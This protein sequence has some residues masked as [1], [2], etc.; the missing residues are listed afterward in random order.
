MRFRG[1]I[2]AERLGLDPTEFRLVCIPYDLY[3]RVGR[4]QGWGHWPHWTHFYGYKVPD[5]NRLGAVGGGDGRFG[6]VT[7]L[8][9]LS[10]RDAR[11]SVYARFAVVRRARMVA[12][13]W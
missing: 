4:A 10:R 12:R 11:Y 13:W 7:D 8:V 3:T 9:S 5:G 1:Q 2:V 6:G